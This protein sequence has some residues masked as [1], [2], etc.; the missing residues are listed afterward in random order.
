APA[1]LTRERLAARGVTRMPHE[2]ADTITVPGAVAGWHALRE[3]FGT[4][5]FRELLAPAIRYASEGFPVGEITAA[6]WA[7]PVRMLQATPSAAR[8]YLVGGRPPEAGEVFANPDL[9]RSLARIAETGR[10]GFYKGPTADAIVGAVRAGG[11][12]MALPDLAEFE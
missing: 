2:G 11:G 12:A 8:T 7:E 4:K 6:A 3:R 10:D 1:G 5:P 9:A